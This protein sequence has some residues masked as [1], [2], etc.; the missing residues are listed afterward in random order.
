MVALTDQVVRPCE[1]CLSEDC[2][3]AESGGG[4]AQGGDDN[5]CGFREEEEEEEEEEEDDEEVVVVVNGQV[6]P[7]EVRQ[8]WSR[9]MDFILSCVGLAV[10]LGNVWRFPY[11]CYKNGGGVFLIPYVIIAFIGGIPIFFLEIALGQFMKQGS[12]GV[13]RIAPLFQGLGVSSMVIIFFCN[14][15]YIM[16]LAWGLYY[17]VHCFASTLPWST[18]SNSW[19]TG[20]CSER[21]GP[22][23]CS[24]P[25]N[26]TAQVSP[27]VEFW[28]IKVLRITSGLDNMGKL[29]WHLLLCLAVIWILVYFCVWKGVKSTGKVVY[30]TA[31]FPYVVLLILFVRGITLPGAYHGIMYYLQPDWSK[32][33]EPQV[34]IDAGTQIFFSYTIGLGVLSAL[35]SYNHFHNN[36]YR[37][38]FM[39]SLVNSGTSFFAGFVVFSTLGF[40]AN[41]QGIDISKVAE[42]VRPGLAFIAYPKAVSMMPVAPVWAALFFVMLL[43]LGLDSQ[44]VG[45]E[46]F[47]TGVSD[48]FASQLHGS[49]RREAFVAICCL[50]SFLIAISMV[51]EGGMYV[52]QLFDHY[53]ASGMTLLWQAC[54]ECIVV[55][56]V[57]GGDRFMD[58][59]AHMIGYKPFPWM[60]WCWAFITP[61]V[62]MGIFVFNLV[63]YKRLMYNKTYLYPVWG[64]AIGWAMALA[65]MSCIPGVA[66]FRLVRAKGSLREVGFFYNYFLVMLENYI[67]FTTLVPIDHNSN[68]QAVLFC[69]IRFKF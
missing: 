22:G 64:D 34:W 47:V 60:K 66:I 11:L 45:V 52:F 4:R 29:N 31:T 41:E 53:S 56:W 13:W 37:D 63:H 3:S 65:S 23:R 69:Y 62:C 38:A 17:L 25:F 9:Q 61:C 35:G 16:V 54:W 15:Y 14:T 7:C 55:A 8:T 12:I 43:L 18:C 20:A 26:D 51:M 57:Y 44:F 10:G 67:F 30:F 39:L 68:Y 33:A 49:Y 32:L 50:I 27:I 59:V 6:A 1:Q 19:N 36:C 24:L 21:L 48:L 42:S 58:D 28:E 5:G 2:E 40:M 46:G